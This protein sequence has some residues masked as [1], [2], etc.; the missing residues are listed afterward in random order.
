[1]VFDNADYG[2]ISAGL[3]EREG[4]EWSPVDFAAVGAALG[5]ETASA[6]SAAGAREAVAAA[7][8]AGGPAVVD[9]TV[10]PDEPT[11]AEAADVD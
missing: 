6:S 8:D 7:L 3:R 1:V 10:P 9:V 2:V 4:F 5:C 11:A